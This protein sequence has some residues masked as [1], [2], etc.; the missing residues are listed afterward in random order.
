MAS[1]A[2]WWNYEQLAKSLVW[3]PGKI[4]GFY[5]VHTDEEWQCLLN[6]LILHQTVQICIFRSSWDWPRESNLHKIL[7][8][9]ENLGST[10]PGGR[11]GQASQE[12]AEV[13]HALISYLHWDYGVSGADNQT[14][15][16]TTQFTLIPLD[17]TTFSTFSHITLISHKLCEHLILTWSTIQGCW[18]TIIHEDF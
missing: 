9:A 15:P 12:G 2:E 3:Y 10:P 1:K 16:F 18:K 17:P 6:L 7:M 4:I 11:A 13:N 5:T 8:L 14:L